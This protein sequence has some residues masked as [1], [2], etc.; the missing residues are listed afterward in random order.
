MDPKRDKPEKRQIREQPGAAPRVAFVT[1][2]G[3]GIGRATALRLAR[4]GTAVA[5]FDRDGKAAEAVAQEIEDGGGR[6][7][8]QTGDVTRSDDLESAV[9]QTVSELGGLDA[10]AAC[11]GFVV[12]GTVETTSAADWDRAIA[13]NLTGVMLTARQAIPAMVASGGGGFVAIASDVGVRGAENSL[14]YSAS[15]H[16]VVGLIRCLALD[17]AAEGVRSNV[18]CPSLVRTP[19]A[20][21]VFELIGAEAQEASRQRMPFGRF[22][23]AEEVAAVVHHLLSSD[24]SYTN[25]MVY[26]VDAGRSAGIGA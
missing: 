19:M 15:K 21:R 24:S 25:G 11:A 8:A 23:V 2:A 6:A 26:M 4:N 10:A 14:A 20:E 13:V 12:I 1:G 22:A 9:A 16:G 3:S 18:V 5:A 7:L 17:H